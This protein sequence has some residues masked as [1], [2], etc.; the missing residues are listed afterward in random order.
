MARVILIED[1]QDI[2]DDIAEVL[3]DAG[4]EVVTAENGRLGLQLIKFQVPDLVICD[5]IMPEMTGSEVINALHHEQPE[6]ATIP[7]IFISALAGDQDVKESMGLGA[8]DYIIKPIDFDQLIA[9]VHK[10]IETNSELQS[11]G[12]VMTKGDIYKVSPV[13]KA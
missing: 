4:H 10:H 11:G 6:L 9:S 5:M 13:Q 2:R 8:V 12:S 3:R 1:E 7:V